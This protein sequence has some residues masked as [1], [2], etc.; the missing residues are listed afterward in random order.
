MLHSQDDPECVF[1]FSII[2]DECKIM[3]K[4]LI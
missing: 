4:N 2:E 3:I 1:I